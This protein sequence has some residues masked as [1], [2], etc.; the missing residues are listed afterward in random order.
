MPTIRKFVPINLLAP[1]N[2]ASHTV[3]AV[4]VTPKKNYLISL[5]ISVWSISL[6]S[7]Y[8]DDGVDDNRGCL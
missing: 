5:R 7:G 8:P 2:T 3:D 4:L 6:V 1:R